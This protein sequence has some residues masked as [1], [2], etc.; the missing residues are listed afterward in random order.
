MVYLKAVFSNVYQG[1]FINSVDPFYTIGPVNWFHVAGRQ[2]FV[3]Y[4]GHILRIV[5]QHTYKSVVNDV[6]EGMCS[7][8]VG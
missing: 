1:I 5:S 4:V 7:S 2:L 6:S 3:W 8:F